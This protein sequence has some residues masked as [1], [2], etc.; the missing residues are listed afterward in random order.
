MKPIRLSDE[1]LFAGGEPVE[2][3]GGVGGFCREVLAEGKRLT[4]QRL[5][6][7]YYGIDLDEDAAKLIT[8]TLGEVI[9][10]RLKPVIEDDY[11]RHAEML[12]IDLA[13]PIEQAFYR[14]ELVDRL[15]ADLTRRRIDALM[16][17]L[18]RPKGTLPPP[19]DTEPEDFV[20]FD[21]G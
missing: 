20:E 16:A 19:V 15:V 1:Q 8:S 18:A 6:K 14:Y 10:R 3:A 5:P 17:E 2:A 4:L 12:D 11:Q 21:D 9:L 13:A 7:T